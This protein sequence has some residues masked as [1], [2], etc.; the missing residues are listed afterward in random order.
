MKTLKEW[1]KWWENLDKYL[2]AEPCVIDE[3]L[4]NYIWEVTI[5]SFM[6]NNFIQMWESEYDNFWIPNYI[7]KA[8]V[9]MDTSLIFTRNLITE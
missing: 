3:D 5:P 8:D 2:W 1:E 6:D 4:Y 7:M 9:L